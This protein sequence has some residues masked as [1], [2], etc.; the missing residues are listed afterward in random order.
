MTLWECYKNSNN[1]KIEFMRLGKK[2]GIG[3]QADQHV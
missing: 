3:D 1:L 2:L